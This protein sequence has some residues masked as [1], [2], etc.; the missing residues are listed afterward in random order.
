MTTDERADV[1]I[2]GAGAAGL[3]AA[4]WAGRTGPGRRIVLLDGARKPGAKILISGGGRC[5]VTHDRVDASAYAGSSRRSI[6]KVLRRFDVDRTVAFFDEL[7]VKLK[8]EPTGRLF[9]ST[10][11]AQTVLDAL[12]R[13]VKSADVTLLHPRR[14][15][16]ITHGP[17]ELVV[18]GPWGRMGARSVVL[19]TGGMSLPKTGSDGHGYEIARSLGHTITRVFPALVPLTLPKSYFITRLGGLTIDAILEVVSTTGKRLASFT[20]STLCTHFGLSGPSVLDISRH[21]TEAVMMDRGAR[22]VINW[23]LRVTSEKLE[24]ELLALGA[25]SVSGCLE[26]HLPDRLAAALC[27]EAGVDP[28]TSGHQLRRDDR[29]RLALA[30]THMTLPVTGDRGFDHAEITAG[31]VPLA[32]M[33][34]DTMESRLCPGLHLC[35]EICDVDGRVGGFNFQWA[36]ASGYTAGVAVGSAQRDERDGG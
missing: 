4:I 17:G 28:K 7:G 32:E 23:L 2:V 25:R 8:R 14:V 19:A 1:V 35:G 18:S 26:R 36:W 15:E 30:V 33:R 20:D 27:A 21:Y 10:D 31:G 29:K 3:V 11:R 12:L 9:P 22:L 24:R 13:G 34:L 16:T 6:Q 5:N